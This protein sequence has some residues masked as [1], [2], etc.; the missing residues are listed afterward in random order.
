[1]ATI[2]AAG[3]TNQVS[4]YQQSDVTSTDGIVYYR[5]I[6]EDF[7]GVQTIYGP[8][9][10]DCSSDVN[11]VNV[12][13][14]PTNDNFVVQISSNELLENVEMTV[15]D[16]SGKLVHSDVKDVVNG[17]SQFYVSGIALAKGVYT[18]QIR[19]NSNDEQRFKPVKLVIN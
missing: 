19:T 9:S 2:P 18:V 17:E 5:L 4:F 15:L 3:T 16:M 10:T 1:V 13:P 14:N 11:E 12:Y 8:I 6:Q 7:D